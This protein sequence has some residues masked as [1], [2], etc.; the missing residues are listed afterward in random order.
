M[1]CGALPLAVGRVG[2]VVIIK[3]IRPLPVDF[4]SKPV[5]YIALMPIVHVLQKAVAVRKA[6]IFLRRKAKTQ[7]LR[8]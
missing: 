1:M 3:N 8:Q 7:L 4:A 6:I 5:K 2:L